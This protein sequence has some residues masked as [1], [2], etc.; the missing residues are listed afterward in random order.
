[1][2][3]ADV[4]HNTKNSYALDL[5]TPATIGYVERLLIGTEDKPYEIASI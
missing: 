2:K 5:F 1:M 4:L 3:L